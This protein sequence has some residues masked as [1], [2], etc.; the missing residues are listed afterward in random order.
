MMVK[1]WAFLDGKKTMIAGWFGLA[2]GVAIAV[3][4]YYPIPQVIDLLNHLAGVFG[5]I[6]ALGLAHKAQKIDDNLAK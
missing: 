1:L 4:N 2:Y 5:G 3:N 6:G